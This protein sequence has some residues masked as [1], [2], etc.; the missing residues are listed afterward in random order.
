MNLEIKEKTIWQYRSPA[1]AKK[2]RN[3]ILR[4]YVIRRM[5]ILLRC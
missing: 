1:R 3:Q 5:F 2:D 4:N